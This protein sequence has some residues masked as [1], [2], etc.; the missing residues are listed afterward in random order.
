MRAFFLAA[1]CVWIPCTCAAEPMVLDTVEVAVTPDTQN[2]Y[3]IRNWDDLEREIAVKR[4]GTG[5]K[6]IEY[7]GLSG[8]HLG[9]AIAYHHVFIPTQR[10]FDGLS[11]LRMY[12]ASAF[13]GLGLQDGDHGFTQAVLETGRSQN[14]T[15][16]QFD[17]NSLQNYRISA[18][19]DAD[20]L[21]FRVWGGGDHNRFDYQYQWRRAAFEE[22]V[23]QVGAMVAA[24]HVWGNVGADGLIVS[25]YREAA[26][27][28]VSEY[29][30][31]SRDALDRS[32]DT[33]VGVS[34][35]HSGISSG[36]WL[37]QPSVS[38]S[39]RM[40]LH[41][42]SNPSPLVGKSVD[43][44]YLDNSLSV[45]FDN[46]WSDNLQIGFYI[47]YNRNDF[48]DISSDELLKPASLDS[49]LVRSDVLI[50]FTHDEHI[51]ALLLDAGAD[52][53]SEAILPIARCRFS[54]QYLDVFSSSVS[55]KYLSRRPNYSEMYYR[56]EGIH[57]NEELN[58][59]QGVHGEL[60]LQI[61][62]SEYTASI[63]QN[64][65]ATG[66]IYH[67]SSSIHWVPVTSYLTVAKNLSDVSG[68]GISIDARFG[69]DIAG[70]KF[71]LLSGYRYTHV[72]TEGYDLPFVF[73]HRFDTSLSIEYH[74]FSIV[75]KYKYEHGAHYAFSHHASIKDRHIIDLSA[76]YRMR[77]LLFE[78][79]I[80][81]LRDDRTMFDS[82]Q[83]PLPGIESGVSV[84]YDVK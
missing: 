22:P 7:Q 15:F 73:R 43:Q 4:D 49:A 19:H 2:V 68:K 13:D 23:N 80:H 29:P 53:S 40:N 35:Y 47:H 44:T 20:D 37:Y 27:G 26:G 33:L 14:G 74:Q 48:K 31:A 12:P 16:A 65:S 39:N 41:H 21:H 1:L 72:S 3:L 51:F 78:L 62:L 18:G 58:P 83:R 69:Y 42:Y 70:L 28:G 82:R 10:W 50:P 79:Y 60:N 84:R 5:I 24:S 11:E 75:G 76:S 36:R 71:T 64:I 34:L 59:E 17:V 77:H 63:V 38:V 8:Q 56:S 9:T 57:G 30:A 46:I 52:I 61:G 55:A 32:F 81:N 25:G 6:G 54:Y 67:Y 45:N 66:Y